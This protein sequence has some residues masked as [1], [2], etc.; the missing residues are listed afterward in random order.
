MTID[1]I[2]HKLV[3][4]GAKVNDKQ[5][6]QIL[7][8]VVALG[9]IEKLYKAAQCDNAVSIQAVLEAIYEHW[10]NGSC[11]LRIIEEIQ[12]SVKA[13]PHVQPKSTTKPV[14]YSG[15]GY[16]DGNIVYDYAECPNCGY[17]YEDGDKDW[18]EPFC[19]HCGQAL[20]WE[21]ES[22]VEK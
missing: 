22:E 7:D 15:D 10:L 1:E 13:L 16:A 9:D 6:E 20:K 3:E 18:K 4:I 2:T 5:A 12:N 17:E 19:P 21:V 14:T 11:A 8:I